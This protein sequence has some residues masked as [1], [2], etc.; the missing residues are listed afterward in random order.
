MF[1]VKKKTNNKGLCLPPG[2]TISMIT[3]LKTPQSEGPPGGVLQRGPQNPQSEG[4]SG[5]L[6]PVPY[7]SY[8]TRSNQGTQEAGSRQRHPEQLTPEITRW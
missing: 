4:I 2:Q 5:L 1:L 6:Q 3:P 8:K 7:A